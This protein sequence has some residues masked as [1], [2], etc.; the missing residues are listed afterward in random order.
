V[1]IMALEELRRHAEELTA[2]AGVQ[3]TITQE[4]QQVYV[5][6]RQVTLPAG[7]YQAASTEVLFITDTQYPLSGLGQQLSCVPRGD[8][9]QVVHDI[10]LTAPAAAPLPSGLSTP[11]KN[12]EGSSSTTSGEDQA[13]RTW[14][15]IMTIAS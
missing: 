14:P 9:Y 10:T 8:N 15:R 2:Q 13:R 12:H 11:A 7:A 3:V 6:L 4:G 1:I 5:I